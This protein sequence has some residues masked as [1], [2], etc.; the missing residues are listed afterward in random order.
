MRNR[1]NDLSVMVRRIVS[2][3]HTIQ[4]LTEDEEDLAL[5]NLSVLHRKPSLYG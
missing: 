3:R 4:D 5:M 2:A 1:K